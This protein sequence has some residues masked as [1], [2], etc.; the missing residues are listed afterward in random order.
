VQI[1]DADATITATG[2]A[3]VGISWYSANSGGSLDFINNSSNAATV[4]GAIFNGVPAATHVTIDG[5]AAGGYYVA[6]SGGSSSLYGGAGIV[7]LVAATNGDTLNA[8]AYSIAPGTGNALFGGS[9]TE[10]LIAGAST[11]NNLF[12]VGYNYPGLSTP[13]DGN[14]TISS[15]G[16][17]A[18]NY[19]LGKVTGETIFGSTAATSN[20]YNIIS[21][22]SVGATGGSNFVIENFTSHS[23]LFF[24]NA[25]LTGPGDATI[26]QIDADPIYGGNST[27]IVLS[28]HTQIHLIGVNANSIES[29]TTS[30]GIHYLTV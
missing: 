25:K 20:A 13:P 24:D 21:D 30:N 15:A 26:S 10:I 28:D 11:G 27:M 6:G 1:E 14:G 23:Y 19:F 4:F 29:G 7:T 12:E 2:N 16:S 5:G 3:S 22:S 9:G 8:N 17:G 18:Q